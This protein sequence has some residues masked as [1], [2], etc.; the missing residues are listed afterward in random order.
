[1]C[2]LGDSLTGVHPRHILRPRWPTTG[3]HVGHPLAAATPPSAART[4]PA[5]Y[6]EEARFPLLSGGEAS[7]GIW[8]LVGQ[9]VT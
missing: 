1:M 6:S 4:T 2:C 8:A 3:S 7:I 9:R 5:G